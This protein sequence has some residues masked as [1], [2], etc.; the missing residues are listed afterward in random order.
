MNALFQLPLEGFG[1]MIEKM[2]NGPQ[3]SPA[4]IWQFTVDRN[5]EVVFARSLSAAV[6]WMANFPRQPI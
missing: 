5:A 4:T 2:T 6:G 1:V 3:P